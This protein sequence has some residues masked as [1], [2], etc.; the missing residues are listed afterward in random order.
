MNSINKS[1]PQYNIDFFYY[2]NFMEFNLKIAVVGPLI[3]PSTCTNISANF[4][5]GGNNE[6]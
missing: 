2:V 1:I 6:A 3:E 4:K 5:Y